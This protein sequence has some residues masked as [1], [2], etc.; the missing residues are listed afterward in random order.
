M[1]ASAPI[2]LPVATASVDES[3]DAGKEA[4]AAVPRSG[5]AEFTPSADRVDPVAQLRAEDVNRVQDLVPIRYGRMLTS[6]FAFFRGSAVLMANDLGADPH[7]PLYAQLCGDAHLSNFGIFGAPDRRLVFDLNDF[8]ETLPGP[9]EWDVKR[10]AAS[11]AIAANS[12]GFSKKV[13]NGIVQACASS[14]RL[15]MRELAEMRNLEVW[16]VRMEVEKAAELMNRRGDPD[17]LK[18]LNK[19]AEKAYTRDSLRE[20]KKLTH[21]VDG[22]PR[23]I[24]DPPLLVP[25]EELAAHT[26]REQLFAGL[27]EVL[28][29]YRH[30]LAT[31]RQHLLSTYRMVHVARKVVGVGSV[32]TRVWIVLLLG[33]DDNDPLFLQVKESGPSVLEAVLGPS[34]FEFSGQRV[35]AGQRLMQA[36]PDFLIGWQN[37]KGIDGVERE[38][39]VRQLK[40]WKGS[41]KIETMGPRDLELYGELCGRVLARAHARS[42][43]RIAI[44]SYLGKSDVFDRAIADFA[45]KYAAQN[46]K[47]F[48]KLQAAEADGTLDVRHGL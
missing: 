31:D 7:T 45:A 16:Y 13:R 29:Q 42:G 23:I 48:A 3:R 6:S 12:L 24:S 19:A 5:L 2:G 34:E 39:Y 35:I 1:E 4:R 9:W 10:L 44:T 43:D 20:F 17:V 11:F 25:V 26:E 36:A 22:E 40:D 47:D 18:R 8:D 15:R 33:R 21:M 27:Q 46:E 37:A 41:A 30:R 38:F 28:D 32:G 14:Y